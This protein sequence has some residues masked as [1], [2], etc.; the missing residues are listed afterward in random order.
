MEPSGRLIVLHDD[1]FVRLL[2]R[3]VI[4]GMSHRRKGP[5]MSSLCVLDFWPRCCYHLPLPNPLP[6]KKS[7]K[8]LLFAAQTAETRNRP[9]FRKRFW[10][11]RRDLNSRTING[12]SPGSLA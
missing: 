8:Q 3:S 1:E 11:G 2:I 12:W 7:E 6:A 5:A 10:C 4:L 9:G